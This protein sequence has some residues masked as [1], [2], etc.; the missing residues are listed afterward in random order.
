MHGE[1]WWQATYGNS[2]YLPLKFTVDLKLLEEGSPLKIIYNCCVA[3]YGKPI[4]RN[5]SH[6]ES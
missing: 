1:G 3:L 4:H 6:T 2:L 5:H